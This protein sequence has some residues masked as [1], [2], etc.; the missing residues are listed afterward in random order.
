VLTA[1]AAMVWA[2][3]L[4]LGAEAAGPTVLEWVSDAGTYGAVGLGLV[5]VWEI[6][7]RRRRRRTS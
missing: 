6:L 2:I 4:T 5:V 7:R 3:G 1:P